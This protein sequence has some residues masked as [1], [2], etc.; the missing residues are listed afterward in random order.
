MKSKPNMRVLVSQN[1]KQL[2]LDNGGCTSTHG[3]PEGYFWAVGKADQIKRLMLIPEID[4]QGYPE[5][6]PTFPTDPNE[7]AWAKRA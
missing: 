5:Q 1:S 4:I 2:V 7:F 6:V 3:C